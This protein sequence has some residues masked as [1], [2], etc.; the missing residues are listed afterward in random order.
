MQKTEVQRI[1]GELRQSGVCGDALL[2]KFRTA[3]R[4]EVKLACALLG[5]FEQGEDSYLAY[6]RSRIRPAVTALVLEGRVRELEILER[7]GLLSPSLSE[8][9]LETA[10]AAHVPEAIVWLLKQKERRGGFENGELAL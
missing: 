5:Y 7:Q 9:A 4:G 1:G 6:L 10:I 8:E 2:R 3:A